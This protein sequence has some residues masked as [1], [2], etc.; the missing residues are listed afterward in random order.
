MRHESSIGH[1]AKVEAMTSWDIVADPAAWAD[2]TQPNLFG[3]KTTE[4]MEFVDQLRDFIPFWQDSIEAAERG[5]TLRFE[6]FLEK[7][8][9]KDAVTDGWGPSASAANWGLHT[10]SRSSSLDKDC[11]T[12]REARTTLV[13]SSSEGSEPSGFAEMVAQLSPAVNRK[14]R[15]RM[16][17]FYKV[18]Q[19]YK[20]SNLASYLTDFTGTNSYK[21]RAYSAAHT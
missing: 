12:Q 19:T 11:N 21:S 5:E 1:I 9:R 8:R 4:R 2:S 10:T 18:C 13:S 6:D 3:S 15:Q 7:V 16:R 20:C 17:S 14:R